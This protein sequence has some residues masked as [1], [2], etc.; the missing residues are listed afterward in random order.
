MTCIVG[1]I[2][3][4]GAVVM[5]ADS[6]VTHGNLSAIL[7]VPKIIDRGNMLIGVTGDVRLLNIIETS[8][9]IPVIPEGC[10]PRTYILEHLIPK[11]RECAKQHGH[12]EVKDQQES[13][14]GMLLIGFRGHLFSVGYYYSLCEFSTPYFAEGS[15][16]EVALGA[17]FATAGMDA[18]TRITMALNAAC[19]L[20]CYVR[21]PFTILR[22]EW[23]A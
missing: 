1:I 17:L 3:P 9:T 13:Q 23:S 14:G 22:K 20:T 5:G 8:L 15:G 4:S 21:P 6:C 12:A 18:E 16:R 10:S 2:E 19:N 7:S 11:L